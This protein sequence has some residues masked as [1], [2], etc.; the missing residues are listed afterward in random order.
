MLVRYHNSDRHKS[1]LAKVQYIIASTFCDL[2]SHPNMVERF[3]Y[4]CVYQG[5][6]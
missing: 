5:F 1:S 2:Q 6:C 3:T 4:F